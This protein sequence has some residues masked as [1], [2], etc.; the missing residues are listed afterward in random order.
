M[1]GIKTAGE[2]EKTTRKLVEFEDILMYLS[3][4]MNYH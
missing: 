2:I 4:M 3:S 1:I